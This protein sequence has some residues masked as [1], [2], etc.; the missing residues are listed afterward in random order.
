MKKIILCTLLFSRAS[1]SS[2]LFRMMTGAK[3]IAQKELLSS[4]L[5]LDIMK[6]NVD[7]IECKVTGIE[8]VATFDGKKI[9]IVN[10]EYSWA[11]ESGLKDCGYASVLV[12][13]D[14]K[15]KTTPIWSGFDSVKSDEAKLIK[16][17]NQNYLN[18]L[19]RGTGTLVP[20]NDG[21]LTF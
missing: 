21:L 9:S 10:Y 19:I 20:Q 18:I 7:C 5:K 1:L 11:K 15:E 12:T 3:P 8:S 16:I 17:D 2:E 4:C 14:G 13:G 6:S